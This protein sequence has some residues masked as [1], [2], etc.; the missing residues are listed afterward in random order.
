MIYVAVRRNTVVQAFDI[1]TT[2]LYPYAGDRIFAWVTTGTDGRSDVY[3]GAMDAHPDPRLQAWLDTPD[4]ERVCH[5]VKFEWSMLHTHGYRV[6][7]GP[8]HV[9]HDT[10][11]QARLI[12]N[13][14][15]SAELDVVAYE[16]CGYPTALDKRVKEQADLVGWENVPV[17][18]MD[19]YQRAD[20]ER[21]VII[22]ET[23]YPEI[24]K[25]PKLLE[26]Y[27]NEIRLIEVTRRMEERGISLDFNETDRV[28][29]WCEEEVGRAEKDLVTLL[30]EWFNLGSPRQVGHILFH[31]L[32]L[33]VIA[34][35]RTGEPKTDKRIIEIL[36]Q[37]H[38]HPFFE[39]LR[40]YRSYR[41]GA[42]IV[43]GYKA[44]ARD[45]V[46]H[47]NIKTNH[48]TTGREASER[49]NLQN[50]SKSAAGDK[51]PYPIPARRCFRARTGYV[52]MPVDQSG[53]EM[54]LIIEAAQCQAMMERMRN[55]E[56]PHIIFCK[57]MFGE[58]FDKK[59][60]RPK[61][62]IGKNG[63]FAL[64]YGAGA[65]KIAA[66]VALPLPH[67][68][69]ALL[70]YGRLFPEIVRLVP[71]GLERV[72]R[73]GYVVTPFGRMLYVPADEVYAWLNY[74]IQGTAAGILKRGQVQVQDMLDSCG[75][76]RDH[77]VRMLLPIHDE[78]IYEI[79]RELADDPYEMA[80]LQHRIGVCM[81]TIDHIAVPL[82]VEYKMSSTT[83]EEAKGVEIQWPERV[84]AKTT[85][86]R[87]VA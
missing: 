87:E 31:R 37:T 52:L 19:A 11:I 2:G 84:N 16:L 51:N 18:L 7:I 71:S 86:Y 83:W 8:R 15:T 25:N 79:H 75:Y 60:M 76:S 81:T 12:R 74:Y 49:P 43:A 26:D 69:R 10:Q 14:R 48:A 22:H 55:G 4:I 57:I 61:Y 32:G 68:K 28:V 72:K 45:G 70:E 1:E 47:S 13:D 64:G 27:R 3:R 21:T 23:Y 9:W 62:D 44:L 85:R 56:H 66:T 33:P 24:V 80:V 39:I 6:T 20:G 50:V 82:E 42:G 29:A 38:P 35:G 59:T 30:G 34:R 40:R 41:K 77:L 54:R 17:P 5:N 78:I 46:I 58:D 63:H 67:V 65:P 73:D 36:E 53:I